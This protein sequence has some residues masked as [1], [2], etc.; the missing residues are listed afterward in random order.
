M[1]TKTL[2]FP[3][4][5]QGISAGHT[6]YLFA[7]YEIEREFR[8]RTPEFQASTK[9]GSHNRRVQ[10]ELTK[11][12]ITG[13]L[14]SCCYIEATVNFVGVTQVGQKYYEEVME[15]LSTIKKIELLHLLVKKEIV[16]EKGHEYKLIK[17]LIKKRDEIV[18]PKAKERSEGMVA[19]HGLVESL[20]NEF[21]EM[22]AALIAF[23]DYIVTLEPLAGLGVV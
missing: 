4:Q 1:F 10:L 23:R 18:H 11:L 21:K 2:P 7:Y 17:S 6:D 22:D 16:I 19:M 8:R 5:W 9:G 13:T 20:E 14:T 15:S 3:Y 12:Y